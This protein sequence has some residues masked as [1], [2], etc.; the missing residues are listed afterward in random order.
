[1]KHHWTIDRDS[2]QTQPRAT[3]LAW[4]CDRCGCLLGFRDGPAGSPLGPIRKEVSGGSVRVS[5]ASRDCDEELA[6]AS[7]EM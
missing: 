5:A 7:L 3:S 6:R 1:M 2:P 4:R